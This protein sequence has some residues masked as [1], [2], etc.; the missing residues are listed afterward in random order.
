VGVVAWRLSSLYATILTPAAFSGR[1]AALEAS[2]NMD[3]CGCDV[4]MA[5]SEI[6]IHLRWHNI[7]F[8]AVRFLDFTTESVVCSDPDGLKLLAAD[9]NASS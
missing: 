1:L 4:G 6:V 7:N 2:L 3:A 5:M 8:E 9:S